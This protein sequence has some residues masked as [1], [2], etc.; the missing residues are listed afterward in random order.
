MGGG[1]AREGDVGRVEGV[2][3]RIDR[4][5]SAGLLSDWPHHGGEELRKLLPEADQ[6]GGPEVEE[7]H[8][9]LPA[10][11]SSLT[12]QTA[13]SLH[14]VEEQSLRPGQFLL[15]WLGK[16]EHGGPEN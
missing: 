5:W 10:V 13:S 1:G 15:D 6:P 9:P 3:G 8:L 12:S 14:L 2:E 16:S 4:G 11:T 7:L